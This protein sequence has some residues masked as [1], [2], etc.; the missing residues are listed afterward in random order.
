MANKTKHHNKNK[1]LKKVRLIDTEN[2]SIVVKGKYLG[3][4]KRCFPCPFPRFNCKYCPYNEGCKSEESRNTAIHRSA[5]TP[6]RSK[7]S[8]KVKRIKY[9]GK[10]TI[11]KSHIK[12]PGRTVFAGDKQCI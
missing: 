6:Y 9:A 11:N 3:E 12:L 8:I 7:A 2:Y 5:Q 4:K 10:H 1:I